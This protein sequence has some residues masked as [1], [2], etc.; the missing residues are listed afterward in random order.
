VS[1]FQELADSI[2]NTVPVYALFDYGL[3][4]T[5]STIERIASLYYSN[6]IQHC[7]DT[8]FHLAGWSYGGNIAFEIAKQQ[9]NTNPLKQIIMFDSWAIHLDI[10]NNK[11]SLHKIITNQV[12]NNSILMDDI[13]ENHTIDSL[14]NLI[15]Q[16]FY[17]LKKYQYQYIDTKVILFKAAELLQHISSIEKQDNGWGKISNLTIHNVPGSHETMLSKR[18]LK[19]YINIINRFLNE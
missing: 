6:I 12:S 11:D 8:D 4:N 16:R 10:Y 5:P 9:V 3:S 1:C 19:Y 17:I 14:V 13:F 15:Y 7:G 2:D 18:M